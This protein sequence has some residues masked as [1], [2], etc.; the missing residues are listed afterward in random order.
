MQLGFFD[1]I[2]DAVGSGWDSLTS[3]VSGWFGNGDALADIGAGDDSYWDFGGT[4]WGVAW[5][6]PD[7]D[8]ST[9]SAPTFSAPTV[10]AGAVWDTGAS[11]TGFFEGF[12]WGGITDVLKTGA[13]LYLQYEQMQT[14]QALAEKGIAPRP[15]TGYTTTGARV[16]TSGGYSY[17]P[18]YPGQPPTTYDASGRPVYQATRTA[19]APGGAMNMQTLLPI[20]A[21]GAGAFF[22]MK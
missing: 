1:E 7:F 13:G 15:P 5:E 16:P 18:T 4:E 6:A 11:G 20:L 17:A 10:D 19:A 8:F 22:L 14:Q 3:E 12:D 9:A 2:F 21:I